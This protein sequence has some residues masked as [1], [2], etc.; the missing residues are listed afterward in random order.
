MAVKVLRPSVDTDYYYQTDEGVLVKGSELNSFDYDGPRAILG[1]DYVTYLEQFY[2]KTLQDRVYQDDHPRWNLAGQRGFLASWARGIQ[3][4]LVLLADCHECLSNATEGSSDHTY[5]KEIINGEHPNSK[6]QRNVFWKELLAARGSIQE[7]LYSSIDAFNRSYSLYAFYTDELSLP[8]GRYH[9]IIGRDITVE[10]GCNTWS[11]LDQR[12][13][14]MILQQRKVMVKIYKN[15]GLEGMAEV[16]SDTNKDSSHN[17]MEIR[18]AFAVSK[19][20][21]AAIT[22]WLMDQAKLLRNYV[23][24]CAGEEDGLGWLSLDSKSGVN[25]RGV[26]LFILIAHAWVCQDKPSQ[27]EKTLDDFTFDPLTENQ[28]RPKWRNKTVGLLDT[29]RKILDKLDLPSRHRKIR[30]S[31]SLRF[32]LLLLLVYFENEG[33]EITSKGIEAVAKWWLALEEELR[34]GDRIHE[35]IHYEQGDQAVN[36]LTTT[37]G[38]DEKQLKIR[39]DFLQTEFEAS[40]LIEDGAVRDSRY[41]KKI[42]KFS[43][44]SG[45][46]AH[47]KQDGKCVG[48]DGRGCPHDKSCDLSQIN[49]KAFPLDHIIPAKKG[50]LSIPINCQVLCETCNIDKSDKFEDE[51]ILSENG[52]VNHEKTL[53]LR[54]ERIV[55]HT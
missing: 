45:V 23:L 29:F 18:G 19:H 14:E 46:A 48:E 40:G 51:I 8:S 12:L 49:T 22:Y 11:T 30:S 38:P 20:G 43:F 42:G 16:W 9:D 54:N 27:K 47:K 24:T 32:D 33:L 26:E 10:P 37:R 34:L 3:D 35:P 55:K 39:Y 31:T 28:H 50:G 52:I 7:W 4:V 44:A 5:F 36:W 41:R 15:I 6:I 53:R 1:L 2:M 21:T 25:R 13:K 17:P